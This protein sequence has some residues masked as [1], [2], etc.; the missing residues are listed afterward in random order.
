M[1]DAKNQMVGSKLTKLNLEGYKPYFVISRDAIAIEHQDNSAA[2]RTQIKNSLTQTSFVGDISTNEMNWFEAPTSSEQKSFASM[3][4]YPYVMETA[5]SYPDVSS[6]VYQ[7][8]AVPDIDYANV[9]YYDNA[10]LPVKNETV[11]KQNLNATC[12]P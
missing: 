1:R 10:L 6:V 11:I 2:Y 3:S 9:H 4:L 5:T 7:P 12:D 8:V